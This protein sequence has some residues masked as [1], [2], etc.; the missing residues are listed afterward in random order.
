MLIISNFFLFSGFVTFCKFSGF[1][2]S[3]QQPQPTSIFGP[4]FTSDGSS[5]YVLSQP[6]S[7]F[8]AAKPQGFRLSQPSQ[9]AKP[10]QTALFGQTQTTNTQGGLFGGNAQRDFGQPAA[11]QQGGTAFAKFQA[12]YKTETLLFNV[13][14]I[15]SMKEYCEKS[16]EEL[17]IEDYAANRKG[18]Q[19]GTGLFGGAQQGSIF[20]GM[21]QQP[22]TNSLFGSKQPLQPFTGLF[23]STGNTMGGQPSVFGQSTSTFGQPNTGVLFGKPMTTLAKISSALSAF[24]ANTSTF[25]A[26]EPFGHVNATPGTDFEAPSNT[27]W[28]TPGFGQGVN[29]CLETTG[30]WTYIFFKKR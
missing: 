7:S 1:G 21:K 14:C 26:A 6:S 13:Q 30:T 16:L 10:Q 11:N 28:A 8:G 27:F 9:P 20:G 4:T 2:Q 17:R 23:G 25:G 15:T 22:A 12:P 18:P 5:L 3:Q 24:K 29:F 19:A